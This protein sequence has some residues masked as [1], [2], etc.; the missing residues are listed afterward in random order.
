M[1]K[2]ALHTCVRVMDLEK[3]VEFYTNVL[4]MEITKK[5][6]YP[7][8]QFTLVYLAL[9]G[10]DYEVELTYN[11]NQEEPYE[12]GNGYGHI[13]ISVDDLKATHEEYSKTEYDV[14]DL[15]GLSDGAANYF[16]IKDPDGYK[17]E[18][19]QAK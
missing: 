15:K 1:P 8:D 6:D 12:I 2:K 3:S 7:D 11:Y 5:L 16:F 9:P 13:A 17:I 14:T 19:I 10:D 4:G 18:V